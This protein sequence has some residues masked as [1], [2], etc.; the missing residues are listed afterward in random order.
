MLR[1]LPRIVWLVL[2]LLM[3]AKLALLLH[4]NPE[5]A[6]NPDE[7]RNGHIA[8]NVRAGHGFV[9]YDA[10]RQQLRPDAFHASFPVLVYV[11]WENLG[12]PK[13]YWTLLVYVGTSFLYAVA[14][15]YV[16]RTLR[17]LGVSLM[18]SWLGAG[19]FA[20]YPS[21]AYY[22][23]GFFWYENLAMPLLVLVGYK[24]LRL[25][26]GRPLSWTDAILV[27]ISITLSCLFRSYLLAVYA[28]W[29]LVLLLVCWR[30]PAG[31]RQDAMRLGLLTLLLVSIGYLPVLY[32]NHKQFG[33]YILSTQ[34][35]F[36]LLHGHNSF[37]QGR[38]MYNW[39]DPAAPFGRWV[40]AH[41][42]QLPTLNQYQE[43]QAR[44]RLAGQWVK[45]HP[46]AELRLIGRKLQ[47]FF[48][49]ENYNVDT[50]HNFRW[51]P[52]TTLVHACFLLSLLAVVLR[53][54]GL[55]FQSTDALL[56]AP[57]AA[58]LLLSLVFFV[59]YRWRYFAEPAMLMY[60]LV[61]WQRLRQPL[62]AR[63]TKKDNHF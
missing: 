33:A 52:L 20:L 10:T 8:D 43:S 5:L 47:L 40:L 25:H 35:G 60:P 44:A 30:G 1:R 4:L 9:S 38:F 42:P 15:L 61:V 50:E 2:L 21:V 17:W 37:T 49:P 19:L 24:L 31:R 28:L 56:L 26:D 16:Y 45:Q 7:I 3:A 57:V 46:E 12:L 22:I 54:R 51:N 39:D 36:E 6:W 41:I 48:T 32:K 18:F 53:L 58:I 14:F 11:A 34:G 27:A 29:L 62:A 13:H 63:Q 59:G 23:G 55:R